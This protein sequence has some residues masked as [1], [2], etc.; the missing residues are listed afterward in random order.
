MSVNPKSI[1]NL[2]HFPK[3][4]SGNPKGKKTGT[5][6]FTANLRK[7]LKEDPTNLDKINNALLRQ[8]KKG[9]LGHITHLYDRIDGPNKQKIDVSLY[10]DAF[11]NKNR[12][13][14]EDLVNRNKRA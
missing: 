14:I 11:S 7:I 5:L 6:S 8:A 12:D 9:N 2:K 3:G 10:S 13:E 1:A 4:V